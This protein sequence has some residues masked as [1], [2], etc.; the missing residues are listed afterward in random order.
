MNKVWFFTTAGTYSAPAL[1]THHAIDWST[2]RPH[3][4]T[5]AGWISSWQADGTITYRRASDHC[6]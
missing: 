6:A 5:P 2:P 1:Y 3:W 4:P